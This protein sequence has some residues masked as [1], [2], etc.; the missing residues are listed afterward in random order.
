MAKAA[1][2]LRNVPAG[3]PN[4]GATVTVETTTGVAVDSLTTD[5]NGIALL[6]LD[7]SP[8][9]LVAE[10][11]VGGRTVFRDGRSLDQM[12]T[13]FP[14]DVPR[15]FRIFGN[16]VIPG[17]TDPG[18]EPDDMQ[19]VPGSGL[20]VTVGEGVI[21]IDGHVY[22]CT[23]DTN[24]AIDAN[25]SGST[26][27]DRVIVRFTREGETL[28]GKCVL[29]VLKGT[30][31][32]G[33]GE[34]LTRDDTTFE[35]SLAR[36]RVING[37]S[38]FVSGDITDERYST[39]LNQAYVFTNPNAFD[40]A[41]TGYQAGDI[42]YVNASGKMVRLAKGT[43]GQVLRLASGVPGWGTQLITVADI[44]D[45]T[46]SAAELNTLDGIPA[47]L[48]A[49]ELGYVDGV[50]S[51]IQ[52]Q[53]DGKAATSHNHAASAITSGTLDIARVPTGTTGSTVALGNHTHAAYALLAGATFTGN[54]TVDGGNLIVAGGDKLVLDG[55][56]G[57]DIEITTNGIGDAIING[58]IV[59]GTSAQLGIDGNTGNLSTSGGISGASVTATG[60]I[61]ADG[62][63]ITE[64]DLVI[65]TATT[66]GKIR[67][68]ERTSKPTVTHG[69]AAGTGGSVGA[70]IIRG[71]TDTSGVIRVTTG[72]S[73]VTTG[74]IVA[75]TFQTARST[76]EFG[77]Q[78]TGQSVDSA[79]GLVAAN[80]ATTG[81]D[82]RCTTAPGTE[83]TVDIF[84]T[85][86][87]LV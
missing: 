55:G 9:P 12:G 15:V 27:Y 84:Y 78:V 20:Q 57:S 72:T 48:T 56:V 36:V 87:D 6:E 80:I 66:G 62:D 73:G 4:V 71:G 24:L 34:A 37:A 81:F 42:L 17:Y 14:N 33:D 82:V 11:T 31:G 77:V 85:V 23:A 51:A 75:V 83:D 18:I 16:G 41:S 38:S 60:T 44:S 13:W 1:Y 50:T 22:A 74:V 5:A 32:A 39:A 65:G 26:R 28:E 21:L 8:G 19:V 53:I 35:F 79:I 47:T 2:I 10:A 63:L 58:G 40:D 46:A 43:D 30:P 7:G 52:G 45:L 70:S 76:N 54:V 67:L 25:A 49:T 59:A 69:T 29:A 86:F 68:P 64:S 61:T 3:T